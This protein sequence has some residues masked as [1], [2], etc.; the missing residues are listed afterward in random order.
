MYLRQNS[1]LLIEEG[2]QETVWRDHLE[3]SG[4]EMIFNLI[5]TFLPD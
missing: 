1:Q 3:R 4:M 2:Q 5:G